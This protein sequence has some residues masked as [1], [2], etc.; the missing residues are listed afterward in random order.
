M[1]FVTIT[2]LVIGSVLCAY[3]ASAILSLVQQKNAA[4]I[5][6][7]ADSLKH[8]PDKESARNVERAFD[9]TKKTHRR[10]LGTASILS[11]SSIIQALA[12]F[13]MIRNAKPKNEGASRSALVE[14]NKL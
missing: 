1:K 4:I 6:V 5:S 14:R 8:I 9:Y 12:C 10:S 13:V 11:A 7:A 2:L 3:E